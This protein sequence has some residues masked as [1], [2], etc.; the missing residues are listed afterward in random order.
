MDFGQCRTGPA[1]PAVRRSTSTRARVGRPASPHTLVQDWAAVPGQPAACSVSFLYTEL[2]QLLRVLHPS[3]ESERHLANPIPARNTGRH[4]EP[5]FRTLDGPRPKSPMWL[6]TDSPSHPLPISL[7]IFNASLISIFSNWIVRTY[8]LA[9]SPCSWM[10]N[11]SAVE[12][13]VP[14]L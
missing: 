13:M 9:S 1:G 14:F 4:V 11:P 6:V 5:A 8:N 10:R 12:E 2:A 3:Q 7:L